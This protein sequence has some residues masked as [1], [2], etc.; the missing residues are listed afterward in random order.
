MK[1]VKLQLDE[2]GRG[3]FYIEKNHENVAEMIIG[4]SGDVLTVYHT[5]VKPEAEGKGFAKELL[6]AM[7]AYS[8]EK[9]FK[10]V[11]LCPYVYAQFSR[12]SGD[13]AD[14]WL[15]ES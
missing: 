14:I 2:S 4:I 12:H 7:V 15:K 13:Y 6:H 10:V 8:R 3:L 1:N 5:E 9:N 11:A